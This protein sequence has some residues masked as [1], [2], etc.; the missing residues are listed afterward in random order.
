MP[1]P[2]VEAAWHWPRP[3][4]SQVECVEVDFKSVR[5]AG[6]KGFLTGMASILDLF[7]SLPF[8][9]LR[10]TPEENDFVA[11]SYDWKVLESDFVT[12]YRSTTQDLLTQEQ[13]RASEL[14]ARQGMLFDAETPD[15]G[16]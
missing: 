10:E 2:D 4:V 6:I 8:T 13:R 1:D 11:L 16:P 7:G 12:T 5:E 15:S 14:N 3:P 9:F